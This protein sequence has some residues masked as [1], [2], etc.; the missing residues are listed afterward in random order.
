MWLQII[1][2]VSFNI[3]AVY[4]YLECKQSKNKLQTY[5]TVRSGTRD[6]SKESE[7]HA[8]AQ[9]QEFLSGKPHL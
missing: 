1:P 2:K 3:I 9:K 6:R 7:P 8:S 5:F 4:L